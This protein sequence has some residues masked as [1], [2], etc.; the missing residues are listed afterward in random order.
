MSVTAEY[1]TNLGVDA[2]TAQSLAEQHQTMTQAPQVRVEL[3][4]K[5]NTPPSA[6][7]S[8]DRVAFFVGLGVSPSEAAQL[9]AQ[10]DGMSQQH[11]SPERIQAER[12]Q[13]GK[14]LSA[15][16]IDETQTI[17]QERFKQLHEAMMAPAQNTWDYKFPQSGQ[18]SA[19]EQAIDTSIREAMLA[20]GIPA[21][22]GNAIAEDVDR[23]ATAS[24]GMSPEQINQ[25]VQIVGAQLRG[26]WGTDF[27]ANTKLVSDYMDSLADKS[28]F[29]AQLLDHA[30]HLIA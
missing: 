10:E 2:A 5:L 27:D 9:A 19:E 26:M 17:E 28:T 11:R 24:A 7:P 15:R 14:D 12:W 6:T 23:I 8:S 30:P 16:V 25:H 4:E 13:E 18:L 22:A 20:G 1:F 21:F 29:V 3:S